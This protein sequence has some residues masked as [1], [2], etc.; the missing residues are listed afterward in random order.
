MDKKLFPCKPLF[1]VLSLVLLVV[2]MLS[3]FFWHTTPVHAAAQSL[4]SGVNS[5]Q[6]FVEPAAGEQPI[7]DAINN[8]KTSIYVEIYLLT[9]QNVINALEQAAQNGLDVRVMLDPDPYGV[10]TTEPA[11]TLKALSNAG[12]KT[13]DSNPAFTYTHE[14]GMVIDGK[15]AYIM[16]SNFTAS[17]LGGSSSTTNREY[18]IIDSHTTDVNAVLGVFNADWAR[19]S[20]TLTDNNIVLSPVNSS[21][22]FIAL[23]NSAQSSLE[24]EAEEMDNSSVEKAI[25]NAESRGVDVQVILPDDSSNSAGI[26]TLDDGGVSV[27]KDTQYYMHAKMMVVDGTEAFVGSENISTTSLTKNR[28]LGILISDTSVI[29]TLESTFQ[30]DLNNSQAA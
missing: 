18:G 17:A 6:V 4:G 12:A 14:K 27:S 15:T 11:N 20:Y 29:S 26:S 25:V 19:S 13:E 1:I 28:E 21:S 9:D 8:A 2:A 24:I 10:G 7:L 30:S 22:D 16:S 5:V 23:I 3:S